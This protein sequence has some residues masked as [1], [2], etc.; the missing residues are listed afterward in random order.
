MWAAEEFDEPRHNV[1]GNDTLDGR[2][3]LL[4]EEL[5]ELGRALELCVEIFA[6][7]ALDH[8]GQLLGELG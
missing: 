7:D 4:G 6:E 8:L 5:A 3:F 2:V 1:A